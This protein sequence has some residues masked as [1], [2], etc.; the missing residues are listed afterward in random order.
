MTEP[1]TSARIDPQRSWV[2]LFF[3]GTEV[4]GAFS[5]RERAEEWIAAHELSGTLTR[6]PLD[7]GAWDYV[8]SGIGR[9]IDSPDRTEIANY[10]STSQDRYHYR[11]G[12]A[13]G[14]FRE[15]ARREW[16]S[17]SV[18]WAAGGISDGVSE[19][20]LPDWI[21]AVLD[22]CCRAAGAV[23]DEADE[24]K[25]LATPHWRRRKL[26]ARAVRVH[27][28]SSSDVGAARD[29]ALVELSVLAAD[30]L[31]RAGRNVPAEPDSARR[32]VVLAR[33][34]ASLLPG[35]SITEIW[36]AVCR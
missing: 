21:V 29:G 16:L 13:L 25:R 33:K 5:S 27:P 22:A 1:D 15:R 23:P 30:I 7:N 3:G 20:H 2:W 32:A 12:L 24:V 4:G 18:D 34:I 14:A 10:V 6:H 28:L 17:G 26:P 35:D 31:A 9:S 19:K 36:N 11:R 8:S